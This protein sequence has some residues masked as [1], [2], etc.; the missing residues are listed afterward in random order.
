MLSVVI[1]EDNE[2]SAVELEKMMTDILTDVKVKAILHSVKSAIEWF[3][4]NKHPDLI[5]MDIR[6]GDG[7][8]LHIFQYCRINVPVIFT[9]GYDDFVEDAF[10]NNGIDYIFKPVIREK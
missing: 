6:L 7:D 3:R 2:A 1:V 5:L 4:L 8:S 9:T 10:K